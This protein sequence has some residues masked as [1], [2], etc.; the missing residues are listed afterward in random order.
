MLSMAGAVDT[1]NRSGA[2]S[3]AHGLLWNQNR[4]Y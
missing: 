3:Y 4:D 1:V 2:R